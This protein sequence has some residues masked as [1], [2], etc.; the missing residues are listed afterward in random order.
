MSDREQS[1]RRTGP[2]SVV[3]A[4]D[5]PVQRQRLGEAIGSRAELELV[6]QFGRGRQALQ[7][8]RVLTPDV[9]LVDVRM[10]EID[11]VRLAAAVSRE[12]LPTRVL[13]ISGDR[14]VTDA[15]EAIGAGAG[16]YVSRLASPGEIAEA[17]EAVAGGETVLSRDVQTALAAAVRRRFMRPGSVPGLSPREYEILELIAEGESAPSIATELNL[18]PTTVRTHLRHLYEK[19]GVSDRAA[20]VATAMR[21]GLLH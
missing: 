11:G 2:I 7:G 18:A 1:P 14:A 21:L 20:A 10:P 13:L 6:G 17:V 12:E 4:D 5:H 3:I 9:A 15:Y 8:I 19:L 16:G